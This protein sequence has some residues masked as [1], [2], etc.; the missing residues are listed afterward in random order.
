MTWITTILKL[1]TSALLVVCLLVGIMRASP[2]FH[3][4][5]IS[6][7]IDAFVGALFFIGG[8]VGMYFL[9]FNN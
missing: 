4:P 3:T 6:R 1:A 9:W 8:V 2:R 5:G 7:G